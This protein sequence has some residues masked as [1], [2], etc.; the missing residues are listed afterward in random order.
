M[1]CQRCASHLH[2]PLTSVRDYFDKNTSDQLEEALHRRIDPFPP[3]LLFLRDN[4]INNKKNTL[5]FDNTK[6]QE[7]T[8]KTTSQ[9]N[10]FMANANDN[11]YRR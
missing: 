2:R 11:F 6:E 8:L 5:M 3:V 9:Y 1:N 4:P 7:N 10:A